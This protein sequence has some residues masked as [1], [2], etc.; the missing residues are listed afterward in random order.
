MIQQDEQDFCAKLCSAE[1]PLFFRDGR[2]SSR[3]AQH[4]NYSL[5][6]QVSGSNDSVSGVLYSFL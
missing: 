1:H 6:A 3:H 2:L 5:C 4:D